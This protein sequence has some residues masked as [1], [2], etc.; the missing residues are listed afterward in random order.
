MGKHLFD[1]FRELVRAADQILGYSVAALCLEDSH[2]QL[3][4]TRYTQPALYVVN[5]LHYL[6]ALNEGVAEPDFV[7][8]HSLGEYCALYAA[9]AFDFE[10][11]L[12]LVKRRG[13]LMSTA[14][15]G[16]MAAVLNLSFE[17]VAA[18]VESGH[19]AVEVANINSPV[20]T[21]LAGPSDEL[22]AIAPALVRAGATVVPLAVSAAFHSR[23]MQAAMEE[24]ASFLV[25]VELADPEIPVISNLHARPYRPGE[26]KDTL[27]RQIRSPVRWME[28]IRFL[29]ALGDVRIREVGAK[30]TLTKLIEQI[31]S[32]S[33][34][35]SSIAP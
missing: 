12:A 8:G 25:G 22:K 21:V 16:G 15:G 14:T 6:K 26:I 11:G 31:T 17:R 9:G 33:T 23:H 3:N 27:V 32:S 2:R 18:V 10:T 4:N 34:P 35:R 13:E 5:I 20:Q 28:S 19:G 30:P 7:A 29:L 24:F 1:E